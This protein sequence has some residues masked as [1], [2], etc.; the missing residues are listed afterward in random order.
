MTRVQAGVSRVGVERTPPWHTVA[1][2]KGFS[3]DKIARERANGIGV[4]EWE[5]NRRAVI[6]Q[7]DF[8]TCLLFLSVVGTRH[9]SLVV[10]TWTKKRAATKRSGQASRKSRDNG[11][12]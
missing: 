9:S 8:E 3:S 10:L 5:R 4:A 6:G 1:S 2:S 7:V 11:E 12:R